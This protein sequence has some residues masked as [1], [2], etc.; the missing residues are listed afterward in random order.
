[1]ESSCSVLR[2]GAGISVPW[3]SS[4]W[5]VWPSGKGLDHG[6]SDSW[7]EPEGVFQREETG[8]LEGEA[9]LCLSPLHM[10]TAFQC[11]AVA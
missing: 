8:L 6:A 2:S 9:G 10:P 4:I 11:S 1:M 7:L 5:E 3:C